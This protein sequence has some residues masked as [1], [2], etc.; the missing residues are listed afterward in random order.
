MD[1]LNAQGQITNVLEILTNLRLIASIE[2]GDKLY[3]SDRLIVKQTYIN[4]FIRSF[5]GEK[6]EHTYKYILK[7]VNDSVSFIETTNRKDK[8]MCSYVNEIITELKNAARGIK[9]L[10]ESYSDKKVFAIDLNNLSKHIEK[11]LIVYD[12][13]NNENTFEDKQQEQW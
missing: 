13:D 12:T 10:E 1:K 2:P 5:S 9:N 4:R 7:T 8:I 3:A 6:K 11:I